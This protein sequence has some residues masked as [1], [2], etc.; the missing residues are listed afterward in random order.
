MKNSNIKIIVCCHKPDVWKSDDIYMPIHVGKEISKVD[1]GIQGDN[2]GINISNKNKSYCELTGLYWAWKNLKGL[3]YI[4]L[5][6]YRRYFN[7]HE[8]G[9]AFCDYK[10]VSPKD[11]DNL[12]LTLPIIEKAFTKYDVI[13]AKPQVYP[14]DL[15]TGY[16]ISHVREDVYTFKNIIKTKYPEY[17]NAFKERIF[18]SNK[19]SHYNMFIMKWDYFDQYCTWLFSILD[20]AEKIINIEH[21]SD[22]QSRIWGYMGERLLLLFVH[23][24]KMRVKYYPI[25]WITENIEEQSL[26]NKLQRQIRSELAFNLMKTRK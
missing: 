24:N 7:F 6:H 21:Y 5:C 11:F 15:F 4:G 17:E 14:V 3:D 26:L 20:E 22:E 10:I 12:N 19:L 18:K 1:L 25:Y 2:T 13:L 16:C 23:Q 9:T 8:R